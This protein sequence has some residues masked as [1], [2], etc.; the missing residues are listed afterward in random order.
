MSKGLIGRTGNKL[1]FLPIVEMIVMLRGVAGKADLFFYLLFHM[2][3]FRV[4]GVRLARADMTVFA[5]HRL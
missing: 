2:E 3:L 5:A 4:C 1:Q